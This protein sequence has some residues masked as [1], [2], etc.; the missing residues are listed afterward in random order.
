MSK[1]IEETA[2]GM[3]DLVDQGREFVGSV[4]DKAVEHVKATHKAVHKHP[5]QA[6]AIAL[7]VGAFMGFMLGRKSE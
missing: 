1:H 4:R 2:M 5:Y 6:V 7:G 3:S